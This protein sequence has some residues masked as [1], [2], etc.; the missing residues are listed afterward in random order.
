M[1]DVAIAWTSRVLMSEH[2]CAMLN[3]E[4]TNRESAVLLTEPLER[5]S[6]SAPRRAT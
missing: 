2:L 6:I 4:Q 1:A 3:S 5:R